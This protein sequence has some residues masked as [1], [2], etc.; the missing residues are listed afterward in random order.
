MSILINKNGADLFVVSKA[1]WLT[2]N[3]RA[4]KVLAGTLVSKDVEKEIAVYPKLLSSCELWQK[5]TFPQLIIQAERMSLYA[6]SAAEDFKDLN[7]KIK[8]V[9][10]NSLPENLQFETAKKLATLKRNTMLL[11]TSFS[12]EE[13]QLSDFIT[14]NKVF[15]KEWMAYVEKSGSKLVSNALDSD[16][17][18]VE[19]A[20]SGLKGTWI[21]LSNDLSNAMKV[22]IDI[23]LPF[24][25]SL[26]IDAAVI[27]WD[28]MVHE[29]KAFVSMAGTQEELL[30]S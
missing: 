13:N 20:L 14:Y 6:W 25:E 23:T 30:Q 18:A 24:I 22:P 7:A 5:N 26:N 19:K 15:D 12:I 2:M 21:S 10:G 8:L 3:T 11:A 27:Q 16:I 9:E 1:A 4:E 29:A 17:Q 28:S